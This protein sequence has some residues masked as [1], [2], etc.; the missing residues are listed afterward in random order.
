MISHFQVKPLYEDR[1]LPGWRISFYYEKQAF[2]AIYHKDGR[3]EWSNAK[4][5]PE[6]ETQLA[7]MIH[8]LM[9]FHVY[10]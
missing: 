5:A 10:E 4:P 8:E 1:T 3:I 9:L 7:G 6:A 2:Q